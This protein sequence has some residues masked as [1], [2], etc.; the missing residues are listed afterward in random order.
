MSRKGQHL[1]FWAKLSAGKTPQPRPGSRCRALCV[2]TSRTDEAPR[3]CS[4]PLPPTPSRSRCTPGP[5]PHL[6][7][8]RLTGRQHRPARPCGMEKRIT[9][10]WGAPGGSP[11]LTVSR[12]GPGG[13]GGGVPG[14]YCIPP[15]SCSIPAASLPASS[16]RCAGEGSEQG[17]GGGGKRREKKKIETQPQ[18]IDV[19]GSRAGLSSL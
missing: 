12:R 15:G 11:L 14:S 5:P 17:R 6:P 18:T 3:L 13:P 16:R 9:S 2:V 19:E 4:H 8:L 7:L 10:G 1:L